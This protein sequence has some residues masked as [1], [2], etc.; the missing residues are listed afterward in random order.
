MRAWTFV[1]LAAWGVVASAD[2]WPQ[3]R[4]PKRD[5]VWRETGI[6][7]K[8]PKEL[9]SVW[10]TPIGAGY[11]GPAVADGRV[12]VTDRQLDKGQRNPL[13]PF[14]RAPVGGSERILCLDAAT[15][16]PIWKIEYPCRYAI[17]YPSGP[18][19]TPTIDNGKLYTVGAMGHFVCADA[20]SGEI[21][22]T[23]N[24]IRDFGT[25]INIWGMSAAPLIDGD[26][27]IVL[28]GGVPNACVVA[29]NKETGAVLWKALEAKDPGY[30]PPVIFEAG[31][32]RQLIIW[33]PVGIYSLDPANGKVLWQQEYEK[34]L[35]AGLSIP[36][37]IFDGRRLFVT[38]F[39]DGPTMMDLAS[40]R[41]T[42]KL[43]WQGKSH[44][45]LPD[46]T[47]GLHA[48]MPTPAFQGNYIYGVCSYGELRC[49]EAET[50]K[51]LWSTFAATGEGRWW[52]AF[53]IPHQD[54]Y[55][56]C[57]EQGDLITAKLTPKGYEETSRAFLIAPTNKAMRRDI[58]W[59]HPAFANRRVYARNDKE[60]VCVDLSAQ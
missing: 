54:R 1:V 29:M 28:A 25:T 41:P 9:K 24:Y 58:V 5:G 4:G 18:R 33:N 42:A 57:N 55:F 45:E 37:P 60:I 8:L 26:N 3:W 44:S 50:G 47:D 52:N 32:I 14:D 34:P 27:V 22:W 35:K 23:K 39:Y 20:K 15:G 6:V 2:D 43:L 38:S 30:A 49:L 12:Y 53:L 19:V 51:R 46:K 10:K 17:S 7:D 48:I 31:G 36:T 40:D 13:N 16:E 56:L 11:A 21:L 59:S